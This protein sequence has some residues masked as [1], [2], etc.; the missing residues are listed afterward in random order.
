MLHI[1]GA[2]L[3]GKNCD[4]HGVAGWEFCDFIRNLRRF[5]VHEISTALV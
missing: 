2:T 5:A 1:D 3:H 4:S